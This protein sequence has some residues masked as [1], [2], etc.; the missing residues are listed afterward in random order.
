MSKRLVL[1]GLTALAGG[2][3]LLHSTAPLGLVLLGVAGY[4]VA[5]PRLHR[6]TRPA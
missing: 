2:P 4:L 6:P 3:M 1:S 5:M